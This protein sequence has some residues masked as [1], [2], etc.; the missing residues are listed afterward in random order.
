MTISATTSGSCSR[1]CHLLDISLCELSHRSLHD[2]FGWNSFHLWGSR[3]RSSSSD[4][5]SKYGI[6]SMTE[7]RYSRYVVV[8]SG[9][10]QRL[11]DA[12]VLRRFMIAAKEIVLASEGNRLVAT[13]LPKMQFIG[14][15][16]LKCFNNW[17]MRMV[18]IFRVGGGGW[19]PPFHGL[20]GGGYCFE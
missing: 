1:H 20:R 10:K 18:T 14:R 5:F 16:L 12:H 3:T 6:E 17:Q 7:L 9:R 8:A 11:Y 4:A 15:I 19:K 13:L 2:G